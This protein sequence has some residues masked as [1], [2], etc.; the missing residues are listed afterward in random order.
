MDFKFN[1]K[2]IMFFKEESLTVSI[3]F[4]CRFHKQPNTIGTTLFKSRI[5]ANKVNVII[6][7][8]LDVYSLDI[9]KFAILSKPL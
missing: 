2:R 6:S 9:F 4:F 1:K 7:L 8:M 5:Y 3:F